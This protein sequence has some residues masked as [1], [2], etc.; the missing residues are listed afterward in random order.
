MRVGKGKGLGFPGYYP[1]GSIDADAEIF[2][3]AANAF[4]TLT[5][6]HENGIDV[7]VRGLKGQTTTN[8]NNFWGSMTSGMEI[9]PF[10]GTT[11]AQ[12]HGLGIKRNRDITWVNSPGFSNNGVQFNGSNYGRTGI[13]PSTSM[14]NNN[15]SLF[16]YQAN[17]IAENAFH[18]AFSASDERFI[19][20]PENAANK[21][22]FRSGDLG[23]AVEYTNALQD[24]KGLSL[25]TRR[26]A[27]DA[28]VY[29]NGVSMG[30]ETTTNTGDLST[31]ELFVGS[32]NN[33]SVADL[34][35][36]NQARLFGALPGVA[37]NAADDLYELSEAFQ[38]SL[39]RGVN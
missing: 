7:L 29:R 33:S 10:V 6:T 27:D 35:S 34:F 19:I 15:V 26:D 24:S 2:I 17:D 28:E 31:I 36:T 3:L 18:G 13:I 12:V 39:S 25:G 23:S 37:D 5:S 32:R 14:T 21:L 4:E 20:A 16:I 38:D 22:V 8:K 1:G 9:F 30:T 11:N